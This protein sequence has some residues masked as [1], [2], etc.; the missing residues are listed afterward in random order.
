MPFRVFARGFAFFAAVLF[1]AT[2]FFGLFLAPLVTA[3][4]AASAT[5]MLI[6]VVVVIM[7]IIIINFVVATIRMHLSCLHAAI[8]VHSEHVH[9]RAR[10]VLFTSHAL[11]ALKVVINRCEF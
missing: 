3:A 11:L 7:I 9:K 4:A 8:E 5:S 10:H 1:M 2:S 6:I